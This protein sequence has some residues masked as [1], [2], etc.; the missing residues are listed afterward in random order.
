MSVHK[1]YTVCMSFSVT[2]QN[3]WQP[4]LCGSVWDRYAFPVICACCCTDHCW[5]CRRLRKSAQQKPV[6]LEH[7]WSL[8]LLAQAGS[9]VVDC[10]CQ[11]TITLDGRRLAVAGR[12]WISTRYCSSCSWIVDASLENICV[13]CTILDAR[14][15]NHVRT[16]GTDSVSDAQSINSHVT[17]VITNRRKG[18]R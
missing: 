14:N 3:Q 12:C 1:Q 7:R 4:T 2:N 9:N 8:P 6:T 10:C 13:T 15:L 11:N 5:E 18:F 16:G 17:T